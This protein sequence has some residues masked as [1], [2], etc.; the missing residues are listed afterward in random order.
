MSPE[1]GELKAS[2][3]EVSEFRHDQNNHD[4]FGLPIVS[5]ELI[6]SEQK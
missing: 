3:T 2:E 6:V 1:Y 4:T 5:S